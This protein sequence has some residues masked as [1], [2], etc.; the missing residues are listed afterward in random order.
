MPGKDATTGGGDAW[1]TIE[2]FK[3]Y[4]TN[5]MDILGLAYQQAIT[6][7]INTFNMQDFGAGHIKTVQEW[8]LF[9]DPSLKIGGYPED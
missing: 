2:F 9:G 1:I 4:G 5:G 8:V 6:S 7:Y 3:Q